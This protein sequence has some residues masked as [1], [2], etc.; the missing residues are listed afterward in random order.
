MSFTSS[1]KNEFQLFYSSFNRK[2]STS[3]KLSDMKT[4]AFVPCMGNIIVRQV[5][6]FEINLNY[7]DIQEDI[8]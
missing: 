5:H 7:V 2:F 3:D 4:I 1:R 8:S 6:K